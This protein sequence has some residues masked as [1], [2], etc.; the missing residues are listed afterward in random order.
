MFGAD[1]ELK[2]PLFARAGT[3][4]LVTAPAGSNEVRVC[5][6]AVG[7]ED[8]RKIVSRRLEDVILAMTELGAT[9]PDVAQFLSEANAQH[10]LAGRLEIDALPRAGRF[11]D[12]SRIP[13]DDDDDKAT[14]G[15]KRVGSE[16]AAPNLFQMEIGKNAK[17]DDDDIT[18]RAAIEPDPSSKKKSRHGNSDNECV[19]RHREVAQKRHERRPGC[20]RGDGCECVR[21]CVERVEIRRRQEHDRRAKARAGKR[22]RRAPSR[23]TMPDTPAAAPPAKSNSFWHFFSFGSDSVS[24]NKEP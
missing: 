13:T 1:Q 21:R 5:R 23:L 10:N 12:R 2:T 17:T 16:N 8:Q 7:Q 22:S 11:F 14:R 19:C 15:K 24:G 18:D 4:I 9:F 20:S 3:C 6:F